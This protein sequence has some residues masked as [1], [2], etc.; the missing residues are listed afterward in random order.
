MN[1]P[2]NLHDPDENGDYR[3]DMFNED[4]QKATILVP[5]EIFEKWKPENRT[6][7]YAI[8]LNLVC[9]GHYR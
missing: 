2:V 8:G 7:E 6:G 9:E 5:R 4:G 1:N 3:V